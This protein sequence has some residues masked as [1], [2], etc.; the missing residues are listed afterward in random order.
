MV[1]S[2]WATLLVLLVIYVVPFVVYGLASVVGNLRPPET[3][4]PSKFL[5]G[6]LIPKLGTAIAFVGIFAASRAV[7]GRQWVAYAGVWFLMFAL[8]RR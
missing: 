4:S 7:W 1:R 6:V 3:S 2:A 8:T 5:L